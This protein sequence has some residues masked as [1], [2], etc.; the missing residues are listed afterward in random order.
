MNEFH[1]PFIKSLILVAFVTI[2]AMFT[3]KYVVS[4]YMNKGLVPQKTIE[5]SSFEYQLS[6]KNSK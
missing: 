5:Y 3:S 4:Y 1:K 2:V 6:P